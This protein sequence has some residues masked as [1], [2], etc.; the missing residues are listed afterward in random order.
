MVFLLAPEAVCD[1]AA[2]WSQ[3]P[4][5]GLQ[6]VV[7]LQFTASWLASFFAGLL[8]L[9]GGALLDYSRMDARCL[10]S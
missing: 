8:E 4:W 3:L 1:D 2:R 5:V 9:P 7:L 6:C 10:M